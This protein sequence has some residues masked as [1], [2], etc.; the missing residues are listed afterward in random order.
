MYIIILFLL[1]SPN[2]AFSIGQRRKSHAP[3]LKTDGNFLMALEYIRL[4][5][6]PGLESIPL[7]AIFYPQVD[8][9]LFLPL[10]CY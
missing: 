1:I 2:C 9:I 8:F 5:I 6:V 7:F 10:I 3:L 4:A